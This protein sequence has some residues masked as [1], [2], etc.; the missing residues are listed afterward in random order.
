MARDP[1]ETAEEEGPASPAMGSPAGAGDAGEPFRRHTA[2]S[3]SAAP[4][5]SWNVRPGPEASPPRHSEHRSG[6]R[7][8]PITPLISIGSTP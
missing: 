5:R 7:I 1:P 6:H 3:E 8:H 2:G 4:G